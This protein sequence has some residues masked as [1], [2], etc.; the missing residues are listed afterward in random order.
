[1]IV[2]NVLF[3]LEDVRTIYTQGNPKQVLGLEM[4][5]VN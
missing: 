5:D 4:K 2:L 1:M 3:K